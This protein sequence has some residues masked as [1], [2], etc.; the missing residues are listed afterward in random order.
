MG[1]NKLS[2]LQVCQWLQESGFET[3][4]PLF[5]DKSVNGS[6]LLGL[7][8]GTGLKDLGIKTRD[9]REKFKKKLSELKTLSEKEKKEFGGKKENKLLK[10]AE[11]VVAK[12]K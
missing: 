12:M 11:K 8:S 6:I 1:F 4:K 5:S 2:R 7:D 3:L 10:K 9:D